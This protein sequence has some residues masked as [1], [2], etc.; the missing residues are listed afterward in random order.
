MRTI[1]MMIVIVYMLGML[2]VGVYARGRISEMDDFILGGKRFTVF[3]LTA[4]IMTTMTGAG[5]TLG[6]VGAVSKRGAGIMLDLTGVAL[7][8][9]VMAVIA[10]RLRETNKRSLAEVIAGDFGKRPQIAVA[11]IA[12]FYTLVLTGQN[13]AAVGRL[14]NYMGSDI[15]ITPTQATVTAAV[16]M[17][18]YTA[19]GGL[20]AV[21]WTDTIQFIVMLA[22]VVIIGPVI[23]VY[24]AGGITPIA[25]NLS[26]KGLS[27]YN[28]L[29]GNALWPS[30][31]FMLIMLL[32]VPGDPTA[33]QRALAAQNSAVA[34]KAFVLAGLSM[35]PWGAALA[36]IGGAA[37]ITMPN[38]AAEWGTAEAAFP[39]FAIKYFPPVLTGLTFA[40]MLAAVMST[41]D[42]MLLLCTT[43]IVYDIGMNAAPGVLTEKR[44]V[45]ILPAVTVVLGGFALFIAL[46]ISSLLATMYFVFSLVSAAF[47]VPTVAQ[48]YL[49]NKCTEISIIASVL[50]GGGVTLIMYNAGIMGPGGDP[51]YTGMA[52]SASCV[53]L[54]SFSK[55]TERITV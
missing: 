51:V 49:P 30:L 10:G 1:D 4:T 34:K 13:I 41:A 21:V 18:L 12:A 55:N 39:I 19:L 8:L 27:L 11:I 2:G 45:K 6:M 43:H 32:G 35:F 40:G 42:S 16:V 17:T 46:R 23:A 20:Y 9:F 38:I 22:S 54:G 28:P 5:M 52:V 7:G 33:P 47:I 50:A 29:A 48:L 25:A 53:F 15:G 31:T 37:I 26:A 44:A 24:T 14:I 36:I 3:P